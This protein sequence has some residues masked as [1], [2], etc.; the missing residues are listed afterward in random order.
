MFLFVQR[1]EISEDE[2]LPRRLA[3]TGDNRP[4]WE[5]V[6]EVDNGV[7]ATPPADL[8]VLTRN[9]VSSAR[10]AAAAISGI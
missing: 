8:A 9:A 7:R 2:C 6:G 10:H 4:G 1:H 3:K 5:G